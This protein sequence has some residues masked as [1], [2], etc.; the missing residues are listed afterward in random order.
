MGLPPSMRG[1][2]VVRYINRQSNH[3]ARSC[4]LI[5]SSQ[6][7]DNPTPNIPIDRVYDASANSGDSVPLL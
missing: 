4:R 3:I 6:D 7:G 2:T 1:P 5:M